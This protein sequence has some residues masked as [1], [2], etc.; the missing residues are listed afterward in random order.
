M[1]DDLRSLLLRWF[2]EVWNQR[3]TETIDELIEDDS[4]CYTEQGP[5]RGAAEFRQLQYEPMVSAFPDLR[6]EVDG[7]VVGE[8][9]AAVR[10]TA[11]GTHT[12]EG[13][14]AAPTGQ[15]VVFQ[16]VSWIRVRDGKFRE[17]WQWSNAIEVIRHLGESSPGG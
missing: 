6:V 10:W 17:G 1:D 12:G 16:G 15:P 4:V 9:E 14:P 5:M 2:D 11:T 3:R 8:G 7:V 13:L